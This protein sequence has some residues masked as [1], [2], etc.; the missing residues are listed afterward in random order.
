MKSFEENW[1]TV[2]LTSKNGI[3]RPFLVQ[4]DT[5]I[6]KIEIKIQY[7]LNKE[8]PVN[9]RKKIGTNGKNILG[10]EAISNR[11]E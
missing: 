1:E 11:V 9:L 6:A 8:H 4:Y 5:M 10:I 7:N 2:F 3:V